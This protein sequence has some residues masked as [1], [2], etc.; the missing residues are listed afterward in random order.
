MFTDNS[1]YYFHALYYR[2]SDQQQKIYFKFIID[3][4]N[5]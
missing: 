3:G 2:E 5:T 4:D 1:N